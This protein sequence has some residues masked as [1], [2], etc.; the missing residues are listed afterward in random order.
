MRRT[1]KTV[2]GLCVLAMLPL[3]FILLTALLAGLMGCEVNDGGALPCIVG[4]VD[5][6]GLLS[7]MLALGWLGLL[8][9]PA[10]MAV[11]GLWGLAE[12]GSHWRRRRRERRAAGG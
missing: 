12:A 4:G 11:L 10:L 6:G 2:I 9:I 3:V 8:T 7:G 5:F 1:R